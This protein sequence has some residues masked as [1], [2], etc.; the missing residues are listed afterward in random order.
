LAA[1]SE[2]VA[3]PLLFPKPPPTF[4]G[5]FRQAGQIS[6]V[7]AQA[8]YVWVERNPIEW[9]TA[10]ENASVLLAGVLLWLLHASLLFLGKSPPFSFVRENTSPDCYM[11]ELVGIML[12]VALNLF[13]LWC[14][15]IDLLEDLL[16]DFRISQIVSVRVWISPER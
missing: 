4:L 14:E 3:G 9:P 15:V 10:N 7:S 2:A 12:I 16:T 8:D 5:M 1:V 11:V 13:C 6:W